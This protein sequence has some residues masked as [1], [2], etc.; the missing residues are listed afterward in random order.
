MCTTDGDDPGTP[1]SGAD[2]GNTGPGS[3]L[4]QKADRILLEAAAAGADLDDLKLIAQAAYEAWR[5][6]EPDPDEDPAG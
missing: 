5:E 2:P 3:A 6:L 1:R 4:Q